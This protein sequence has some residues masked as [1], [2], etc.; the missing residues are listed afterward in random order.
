MTSIQSGTSAGWDIN[1]DTNKYLKINEKNLGP[2]SGLKG[3]Y[4]PFDVPKEIVV[5]T[6]LVRPATAPA[7]GNSSSAQN[8]S[9]TTPNSKLNS[10]TTAVGNSGGRGSS[11][12]DA[13]KRMFGIDA[14]A[15]GE[16]SDLSGDDAGG[17]DDDN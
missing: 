16:Y 14:P 5:P 12:Q 3:P 4:I 2:I 7:H 8:A 9:S 11:G 6:K 10:G 1:A 13:L 15:D 17:E